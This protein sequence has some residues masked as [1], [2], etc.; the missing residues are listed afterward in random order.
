M[1]SLYQNKVLP[2]IIF[3]V[4]Y[5]WRDFQQLLDNSNKLHNNASFFCITKSECIFVKRVPKLSF[6]SRLNGKNWQN[7]WA[8]EWVSESVSERHVI[9]WH[10]RKQYL[11]WNHRNHWNLLSAGWSK[12][13]KECDFH[14][15]QKLSIHLQADTVLLWLHI[16]K[17]RWSNCS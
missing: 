1:G 12:N 6:K 4:H 10:N 5:V 7:E 14:F 13:I 15:W 11:F 9:L 17:L 8:S 3:L 2:L 16:C